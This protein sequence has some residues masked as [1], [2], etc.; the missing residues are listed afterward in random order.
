MR[1]KTLLIFFLGAGIYVRSGEAYA[2][3]AGP[4]VIISFI[5]SGIVAILA[6]LSFSELA[7]MMSHSGAAYTYTYVG[8]LTIVFLFC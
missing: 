6:A 5:I 3:Y 4:S 8:Q 1:G 7:A 2:K